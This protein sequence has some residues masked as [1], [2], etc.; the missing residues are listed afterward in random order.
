MFSARAIMSYFNVHFYMIGES[1]GTLSLCTYVILSF[2]YLIPL[3]K[4]SCF[5][6]TDVAV[7]NL[8]LKS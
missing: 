7:V 1:D 4:T 8:H 3:L 2:W 6:L 5:Y